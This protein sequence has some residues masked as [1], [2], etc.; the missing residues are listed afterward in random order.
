MKIPLKVLNNR[1]F[2]N[3]GV[4][5]KRLVGN[6]IFY[7]D[8][9]SPTSFIGETDAR[10]LQIPYSMLT[11]KDRALMGGTK[12]AFADLKNVTIKFIAEKGL[13]EIP[14]NKFK[15]AKNL[16]KKGSSDMSIIGVDFLTTHKLALFVNAHKGIAYFET[17]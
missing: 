13:F 16:R 11:F 14:C 2:I 15:I 7:I 17:E 5:G 3:A 8:T 6:L 12:I 9:G 10:R 4:R 1:I